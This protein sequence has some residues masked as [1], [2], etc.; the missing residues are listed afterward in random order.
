MSERDDAGT[1]QTGGLHESAEWLIHMAGVG[2]GGPS[3]RRLITA[4][5]AVFMVL[6]LGTIGYALI[7]GAG[8]FDSFYMTVMTVTTVGYTEYIPLGTGGKVLNV[9]V[10]LIGVGTILYVASV[11]AEYLLS[12]QLGGVIGKQRMNRQIAS[13][14]GH[15]IVCGYGRTGRQVVSELKH[16]GR[17]VVVADSSEI[18]INRAIEDGFLAVQGDSGNDDVLRTAGIE[19]AAG[20]VAAIAPDAAVLMTVLSAR[21][22]NKELN[23]VARVENEESQSKLLTAGADRVISVHR[24]AGHRLANM[25][26]RPDVAEFLEVVLTNRDVEVEMDMVKLATQS[27]F[28]EMTLS[29]TGLIEKTSVNI[30]G[31]R[32]RGGTMTVLAAPG[33]VLHSSDVLVAVGS[34]A[35]LDMLKRLASVAASPA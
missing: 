34:R 11:L 25:V 2:R 28:D 12:G 16:A 32:K 8:W 19:R 14:S 1:Q 27:P 13:M 30:L 33:T 24:I 22:L 6:A 21:A 10:M 31:V 5:A 23:I 7:E 17:E 20:V 26:V 29:E 15:Y 9:F 35:Q 18:K 3:V 4:I